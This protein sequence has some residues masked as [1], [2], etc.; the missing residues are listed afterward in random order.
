MVAAEVL[1]LLL[2]EDEVVG[3]AVG[4][5]AVLAAEI[6]HLAVELEQVPL[7]RQIDLGAALSVGDAVRSPGPRR[8]LPRGRG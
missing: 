2:S 1:P 8:A 7:D 6:L 3:R 5:P 4:H